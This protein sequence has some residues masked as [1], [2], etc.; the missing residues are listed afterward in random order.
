[1]KIDVIDTKDL[2]GFLNVLNTVKEKEGMFKINITSSGMAG[3]FVL[4]SVFILTLPDAAQ[5]SLLELYEK[6]IALNEEQLNKLVLEL[7]DTSN[8]N[9]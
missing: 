3:I 1:M 2:A 7:E 6:F 5:H 8:G 4:Y 9:N